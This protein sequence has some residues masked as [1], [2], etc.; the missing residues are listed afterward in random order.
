MRGTRWTPAVILVMLLMLLT[1]CAATGRPAPCGAGEQRC[2]QFPVVP[3]ATMP[4]YR[5]FPLGGAPGVTNAL[6]VVHGDGRDA[7][8]TYTGM[9]NA[10]TAAGVAG[11]TLVAAPWFKTSKDKPAGNEARW[12]DSGWKDGN[13]AT[14]PAGLSSFTVLD[15]LVTVL[16][17]KTRFP[18]LTRI[19]VVGHSAGGQFTQR[20][21]AAG[22]APSRLAGSTVD[23]VVANP[24]SYLYLD[25][26]RPD[27]SGT[28]FTQPNTKCRYNDYKYGLVN[29]PRYLAQLSDQ[30]LITNYTTRHVTYLLGSADTRSDHDLDTDCGGRLQGANRYLRGTYFFNHL[31]ASYP[32]APHALVVVPGVGHD[33]YAMF[34]S[35]QAKPVLF[36]ADQSR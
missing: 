17:D 23:Y 27:A 21:A 9:L 24:S 16:A 3:G 22:Q 10:A 14:S 26:T 15:E 36:P 33:H 13:D 31:H 35:A 5:N 6:V 18:Q 12:S 20:Y 29:R 34:G 30:Q 25:A 11:R 4:V 2:E 8:A 28:N 32:A 1:T 7:V 19:T